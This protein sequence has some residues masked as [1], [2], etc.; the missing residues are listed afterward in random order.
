MFLEGQSTCGINF[1]AK[2]G[3]VETLKGA[4][5]FT[6]FAPDNAAF[7]KIPEEQLI[8]MLK[9]ENLDKL[10]QALLIHVLP[11]IVSSVDIPEG[12]TPLE[13]LGNWEITVNRQILG[14]HSN[15]ELNE[16]DYNQLRWIIIQGPQWI[17]D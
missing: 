6:L 10:K 13:T 1:L 15:L 17:I 7:E 14:K 16:K 2:A 4:G 9:P 8:E 3:L 5:P 12:D 11:K